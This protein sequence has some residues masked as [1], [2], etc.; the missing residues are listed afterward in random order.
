MD[1]VDHL[2][3]WPLA[4]AIPDE[5]ASTV[6]DAIYEKLVLEHTCPQI[7]LSD[8]SK[9]FTN[10]LL[11]YVCEQHNTEQHFTNQY[12]PQSYGK[13]KNFNHLLKASIRKLCQDNM[14]SWDQVIYQMILPYRCG[15]HTLTGE[16]PFFWIFNREPTLPIYKLIKPV[17]PF[18]GEKDIAKR[19]EKSYIIPFTAAKMLARKCSDQKKTTNHRPSKHQF[20]VGD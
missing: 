6:A 4:K 11:S 3:G 16:S 19:T 9:E 10:D 18:D 14:T 17:E 13:T 5:E 20:E 12:I 1:T 7:L 8:N 15:P 2:T